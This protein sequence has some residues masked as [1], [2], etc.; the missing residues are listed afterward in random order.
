MCASACVPRRLYF[1]SLFCRTLPLRSVLLPAEEV[2]FPAAVQVAGAPSGDEIM[3]RIDISA[4]QPTAPKGTVSNISPEQQLL[5]E[6][7]DWLKNKQPRKALERLSRARIYSPRLTNVR[8]L[9]HLHLGETQQAVTLLRPLVLADSMTLR[10]DVPVVLQAT[11]AAALL[12]DGNV[13]GCLHVLDDMEDK[14]DPQVQQLRASIERWKQG[15]SLWR[16]FCWLLG[17]YPRP[18]ADLYVVPT[19]S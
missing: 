19:E 15:L 1:I 10:P 3:S 7:T 2:M 18:P 4:Q 5:Q 13:A 14:T 11:F 17:D 9:C 16:K 6:A 12:M 8:A